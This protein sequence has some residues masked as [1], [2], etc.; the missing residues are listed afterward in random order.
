MGLEIFDGIL[1]GGYRQ[2]ARSNGLAGG[3]VVRRV[4]DDQDLIPFQ[5]RIEH[6]RT[7]LGGSLSDMSPILVVVSKSSG[8]EMVPQIKMRQ[9]NLR[10]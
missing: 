3:D 9:L 2:D 7:A 5:P 1:T 4:T 6:R 10:A 8:T